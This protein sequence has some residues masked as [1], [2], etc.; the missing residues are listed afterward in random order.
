ML[1]IARRA[2]QALSIGPDIRIE[3]HEIRSHQVKLTI[4]APDD[5]TIL[6][7][8][9][10]GDSPGRPVTEAAGDSAPAMATGPG[11]HEEQ[12]GARRDP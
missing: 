1:V 5:V 8:E 3:I 2:G 6:R 11:S 7:A 4:V 9:I 12:K 10:E